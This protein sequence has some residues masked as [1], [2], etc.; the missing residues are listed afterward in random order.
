MKTQSVP[1]PP[2][3]ERSSRPVW[4]IHEGDQVVAA[5]TDA[6]LSPLRRSPP[7]SAI[8][9]AVAVSNDTTNRLVPTQARLV[10]V[11]LDGRIDLRV[12]TA[13][14]PSERSRHRFVYDWG[15]QTLYLFAFGAAVVVGAT[16]IDAQTRARIEEL[17][18]RTVLPETT[19]VYRLQLDETIEHP[20]SEWDHALVNRLDANIVE[21]GATALARSAAMERYERAVEPLLEQ[22]LSLAREFAGVGRSPWGTRKMSQRLG[23]LAVQRLELARWLVPL[24]RP[25]QAWDDP[26]ADRVH[27]V[28]AESLELAQRHGAL[29]HRLASLEN[30]L[31]TIAHAW[32]GRRSRA[33]EWAIVL[34]IVAELGLALARA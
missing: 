17:A 9:A 3:H 24:D 15:E 13:T 22:T 1:D 18:E 7:G 20:R 27:D 14:E 31:S 29:M 8:V 26:I 12:A 19:D 34:L 16:E 5:G 30:S 11:A 6:T 33:L 21:V 2:L 25:E 23:G 4:P 32:E 28:L 10:G